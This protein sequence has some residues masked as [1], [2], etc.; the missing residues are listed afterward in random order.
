VVGLFIRMNYRSSFRRDLGKK[1]GGTVVVAI[2]NHDP[3]LPSKP[4]AICL[5]QCNAPSWTVEK[6]FQCSYRVMTSTT[7]DCIEAREKGE[8]VFSDGH[9]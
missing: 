4:L 8:N 7:F 6:Y 5:V 1:S 3:Y 9:L 2:V